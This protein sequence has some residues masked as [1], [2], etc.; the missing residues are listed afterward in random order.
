MDALRALQKKVQNTIEE[1]TQK[2]L[3]LGYTQKDIDNL[4]EALEYISYPTIA[5]LYEENEK[6][7]ENM[8]M[9]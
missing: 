1:E 5:N 3:A 6:T 7:A 4:F 2:L 8:D 9:I